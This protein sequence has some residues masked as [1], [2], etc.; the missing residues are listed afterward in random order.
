MYFYYTRSELS[1]LQNSINA[2]F[3]NLKNKLR[4]T[5]KNNDDRGNIENKRTLIELNFSGVPDK[6]DIHGNKLSGQEPNVLEAI[7][8]LKLLI[9]DE[10]NTDPVPDIQKLAFIYRYGVHDFK[11]DKQEALRIL[12]DHNDIIHDRRLDN[13]IFELEKELSE[14][15]IG[16]I[17][18]IDGI[19]DIGGTNNTEE[20]DTIDITE[21]PHPQPPVLRP[22]QNYIRPVYDMFIGIGDI[23][24]INI[25]EQRRLL[26]QF[27]RNVD[28]AANGRIANDSQNV[29]SPTVM[30]TTSQSLAN[31]KEKT[32]Q[33][34][35]T[36]FKEDIINYINTMPSSDKRNDAIKSLN[37]V[38][39][40]N[41]RVDKFD[42]TEVDTLGRVWS[43]IKD[44]K[45]SKDILYNQLASMVENNNVV[46]VTGRLSRIVDT[47]SG[48]D[49]SVKIVPE[50]EIKNE[51]LT[52]SANIRTNFYNGYGQENT[53][54]LNMGTHP[55]QEIID[56]DLRKEI[57]TQMNND[58]VK[59]GILKEEK[60]NDMVNEWI[61]DI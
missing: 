46:C 1:V 26:D 52:K 21:Q 16:D 22:F 12:K 37:H 17:G 60:C 40:T 32:D 51:M 50:H 9:I 7:R 43:I 3:R 59:T 41:G 14:I 34:N 5:I 61:N 39:E 27:R 10:D 54:M 42:A 45:D 2:N 25:D 53:D 18:D 33:T 57:K 6:Y 30:A 48:I 31:I 38:F 28:N 44:S 11:E 35:S 49:D 29:H 8:Q 55:N 23:G 47:L 36:A 20:Y 56:N 13:D 19:E 58:Y 24:N 4:N 15:Y